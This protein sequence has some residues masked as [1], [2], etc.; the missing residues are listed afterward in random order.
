[1]IL[2]DLHGPELVGEQFLRGFRGCKGQWAEGCWAGP[3]GARS[4][5]SLRARVRG[6]GLAAGR[7]PAGKTW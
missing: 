4:E 6:A 1:M 3:W 5:V 7:S 2:L